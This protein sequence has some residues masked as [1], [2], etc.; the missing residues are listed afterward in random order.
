M[1][2]ESTSPKVT[3]D[4]THSALLVSKL[5]VQH[6]AVTQEALRWSTGSRGQAVRADA[7]EDCDLSPFVL[8]ALTV[9]ATA[10]SAAGG[11]QDT[12]N[13]EQLIH[14]VGT[15]TTEA[16]HRAAESTAKVTKDAAEAMDKATSG[17][18]KSLAESSESSKKAIGDTVTTARKELREEL[19]RLF[20]GDDP[21]FIGRLQPVLDEFT[22]K[23]TKR[24][25]EHTASMFEKATKALNPDDPTSPIAKQMAAFDKRHA[26]LVEQSAKQNDDLKTK[27][28][29]LTKAIEVQK[30]AAAATKAA[31]NVTPIKGASY[32]ENAGAVLAAL[33][34]GFGDEYVAT[35]TTTGAIP[36]CK[37]GD[38]VLS[39]AGSSSKVVVEMTNSQGKPRSWTD[40][41]DEAERN[42]GA[43]ASLGLV[44][45][46]EDNDGHRVR[47]IGSR[48]IIMAF[49]PETDDQ[50]LLH[51][52]LCLLRAASLAATTRDEGGEVATAKERIDEALDALGR[53]DEIQKVAGQIRKSSD[54]VATQADGLQTTLNRL[55]LQAQTALAGNKLTSVAD[56]DK[57]TGVA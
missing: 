34:N 45:S 20:G 18:R 32:E 39:I 26:Q 6:P 46:V 5:S 56:S 10:I 54:K 47:P 30:A 21:E 35:G 36:Y 15:R 43:A 25:D 38:G 17:V 50:S 41:L 48:R 22:T 40:Y 42:R 8:Q 44:P 37:K 57:T 31:T 29:E 19:T 27:V 52:V 49:D 53:L 2:T 28:G 24:T 23:L 14:D 11:A 7:L 16:T 4:P 33:V 1:N 51:T 9:G 13:L 12:Y 55:L 3:F